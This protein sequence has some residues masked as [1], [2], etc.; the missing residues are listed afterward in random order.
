MLKPRYEKSRPCHLDPS[1]G[2]QLVHDVGRQVVDDQIHRS[3][4]QFEAAHRVVGDDLQDHPRVVRQA[5]PIALERRQHH[6][7]V[8]G[9]THEPVRPG[10]DR[11]GAQ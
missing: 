3:L 8:H 7:V 6:L 9:I 11:E 5:V 1:V 10:A 2:V 4:A